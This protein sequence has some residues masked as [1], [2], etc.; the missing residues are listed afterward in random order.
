MTT[1]Y[2]QK[3]NTRYKKVA[4]DFTGFDEN[5]VYFVNNGLLNDFRMLFD[6]KDIPELPEFTVDFSKLYSY[7]NKC[8]NENGGLFNNDLLSKWSTVFIAKS[9]YGEDFEFDFR[10]N[11]NYQKELPKDLY[12]KHGFRYHLVKDRN[13]VSFPTDGIFVKNGGSETCIATKAAYESMPK[14]FFPFLILSYRLSHFFAVN[15]LSCLDEL[16]D[17]TEKYFNKEIVFYDM[18]DFP[19]MK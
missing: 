12:V 3:V 2:Y 9:Y 1:L 14:G 19:P 8:A 16:S 17:L 11:N 6:F 13:Y 4:E 18:G 5:G 7:W 10:K 15:R